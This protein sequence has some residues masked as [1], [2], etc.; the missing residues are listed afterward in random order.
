MNSD[1]LDPH[2]IK[3]TTI[4]FESLKEKLLAKVLDLDRTVSQTGNPT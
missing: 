1:A 3:I 4:K 2:N